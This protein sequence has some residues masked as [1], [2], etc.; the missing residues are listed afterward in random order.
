MPRYSLH[1][2]Q[3]QQHGHRYRRQPACEGRAGAWQ[4]ALTGQPAQVGAG[5]TAAGALGGHGG[6]VVEGWWARD[7]QLQVRLE[8]TGGE[9]GRAGG[10]G[11]NCCRCARGPREWGRAGGWWQQLQGCMMVWPAGC[12]SVALLPHTTLEAALRDTGVS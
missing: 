12:G 6:G 5:P 8:G 7:Q 3:Q 2:P 1:P 11:T 9:W 10:R 4:E